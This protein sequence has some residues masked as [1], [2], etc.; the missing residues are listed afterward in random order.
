MSVAEC[1]GVPFS[2]KMYT[3]E[4]GREERIRKREMLKNREGRERLLTCRKTRQCKKEK[5]L[6]E[7]VKNYQYV[8]NVDKKV[9]KCIWILHT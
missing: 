9:C 5:W 8:Q 2:R 7:L 4:G 3:Q 1:C 6:M